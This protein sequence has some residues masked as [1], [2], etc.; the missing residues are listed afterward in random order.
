MIPPMAP[1]MR[2][3]D[4]DKWTLVNHAAFDGRLDDSFQHT[5]LHL[6]F[7]GY[8]LP[9]M[10]AEH[11][12]QGIEA[13]FVET[14]V[15]VFDGHEWVADLDVLKALEMPSVS[16]IGE[17]LGRC[18]HKKSH[19]TPDFPLTSIDSWDEL[20]DRPSN[21][22][23]FRASGNWLARLSAVAVNAQQSLDTIVLEDG[24]KICWKCVGVIDKCK[25]EDMQKRLL[26]VG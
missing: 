16:R 20:I 21:A 25:R 23:I 1:K 24:K 12:Y 26:F 13:N 5:S 2:K 18:R 14:L 22:C 10:T 6:S 15:S 8:Q 4:E 17:H 7:T 9:M 19:D 11:G 3:V